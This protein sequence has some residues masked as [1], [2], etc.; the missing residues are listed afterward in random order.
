MTLGF[1]EKWRRL[2]FNV[3]TSVTACIKVRQ[4]GDFAF[5]VPPRAAARGHSSLVFFYDILCWNG[6]R[7]RTGEEEKKIVFCIV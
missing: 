1:F 4:E 7:E 2:A 6:E 3:L 5:S